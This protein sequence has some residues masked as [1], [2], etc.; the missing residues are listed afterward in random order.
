M[1]EL[2]LFN[3]KDFKEIYSEMSEHYL[4]YVKFMIYTGIKNAVSD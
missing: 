2:I 3:K 1:L 4:E